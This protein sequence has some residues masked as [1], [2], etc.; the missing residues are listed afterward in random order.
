MMKLYKLF[1]ALVVSSFS[2]QAWAYPSV[3]DKVQWTGTVQQRDGTQKSVRI[4][5]EVVKFDKDT[6]KWTVK[7]EAT[8]GNDVV[9]EHLEVTDLYSPERFKQILANCV[10]NGGILEKVEA[11][12][13]GTYD[14]CKMTTKN[15]DGSI[16]E[17]WWGNI[18]FGVVS[19]STKAVVKGKKLADIPDLQSIVAGL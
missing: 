10:T 13:A 17:K 15:A 4:V 16:V 3:G 18:P 1:S 5:K 8:M 11:P 9:S 6:K 12:P 19:K 14:T 2:L 7:Y